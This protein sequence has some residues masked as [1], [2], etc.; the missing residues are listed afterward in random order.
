MKKLIFILIFLSSFGLLAEKLTVIIYQFDNETTKDTNRLPDSTLRNIE[1]KIRSELINRGK[2]KF[3]VKSGEKLTPEIKK[4]IKES[5]QLDRNSKY[6]IELGQTISARYIITGNILNEGSDY[7]VYAEMTDLEESAAYNSG[8]A[9]FTKTKASMDK[10][11]VKIVK[12]LLGEEI[13]EEVTGSEAQIACKQAKNSGSREDWESFID[14]FSAEPEVASCVKTGRLALEK[15]DYDD[16]I[17]KNNL[18]IWQEYIG[19]YPSQNKL[20]LLEAK[21]RI[22][23]L[24]AAS[25]N[26]TPAYG[27]QQNQYGSSFT[28]PATTEQVGNR[29]WSELSS[30][31]MNFNEA[32]NYCRKLRDGGNSDWRL[33]TI[34]ELRTLIQNCP[35]SETA[36]ACKVSEE[37]GCLSSAC[38]SDRYCECG[39]NSMGNRS[40]LG[41]T[42]II[43]SSSMKTGANDRVFVVDFLR[44]GISSNS[45]GTRN[46]VRC[47]R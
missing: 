14:L 40:K 36:G 20:H 34:D 29:E 21:K 41:D 31:K 32:R 15:L 3:T 7:T 2:G 43:W 23:K 9:D 39:P 38:L 27:N 30:N 19:K 22:K 33:P 6:K 1:A 25:K 46:N 4:L 17:M 28:V 24:E 45:T 47:T 44:G 42:I 37:E 35:G 11:A 8:N 5:H 12:Q 13:E 26:Q 18:Q 10:A 16:A